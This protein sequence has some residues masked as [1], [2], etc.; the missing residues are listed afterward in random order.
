MDRF[1]IPTGLNIRQT[2]RIPSSVTHPFLAATILTG[3]LT[4]KNHYQKKFLKIKESFHL[5]ES[6]SSSANQS[7]WGRSQSRTIIKPVGVVFVYLT[8][9]LPL[10]TAN[11][12]H[13]SSGPKEYLGMLEY[14]REDEAKLIQNLILGS[15]T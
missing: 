9:C 6:H 3:I 13:L 2:L 7:E 15:E 11:D 14:K 5:S 8:D 4:D 12:V 10:S 1:H